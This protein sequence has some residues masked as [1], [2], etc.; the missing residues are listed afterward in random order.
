MPEQICDICNNDGSCKNNDT[1]DC[2]EVWEEKNNIQKGTWMSDWLRNMKVSKQKPRATIGDKLRLMEHKCKSLLIIL[3]L[4]TGCE[5][6]GS[7]E[8][9]LFLE[10]SM[11]Y[12][13]DEQT[14]AYIVDYPIEKSHW[15]VRVSVKSNPRNRVYFGSPVEFGVYHQGRWIYE[16]IIQHSVYVKDDSTSQQLVYLNKAMIGRRLS[17]FAVAHNVDGTHEIKDSLFIQLQ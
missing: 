3:L 6:L 5:D 4:F 2:V 8:P 1:Y 12:P 13:Y 16:P 11:D 15:Y 7:V 17:V 9:K 14:E 10:L